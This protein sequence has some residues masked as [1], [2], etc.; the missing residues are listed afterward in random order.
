MLHRISRDAVAD[1]AEELFAAG[2]RLALVA[3]HDDGDRLRVVYL[4]LAGRPDRRVE[5]E[6]IL[7]ATDPAVPSLAYL[8]FPAS[9]FE[10]EMADLTASARSAIRAA[11]VGPARALAS[12][13]ASDARRCRARTGI[14]AG[15][16]LPLRH[17]RGH[18]GVRDPGR[19]RA[20]RA[21]RTGPLPVLRRRRDGARL[22]ARL[23][24]VHR[25][26][27]K[28]FHGRPQPTRS[29]WPSGSAATPPPVMRWRTAWRS[30]TRSA[31]RCPTRCTGCGRCSSSS[32]GSTTTPPISVRSPTTSDSRWPTPT[33]Q[34]I[35]ERLLR[36]NAAVTGH[37]L[38]RGAIGPG[39]VRAARSSA[40]PPSL[41][42]IAADLAEVA[43]LTLANS[44]VHDRFAG[45]SVLAADDARAMGCLGYVARASGV[46]TDAR[47]DHPT[48]RAARHR[49]GSDDGDVLAR[50]TVR[51]DDFAASIELACQLI[52][53]HTGPIEYQVTAP[54]AHAAPQRRRHRR[55]LARHHRAPRRDATP[56]AA[57][58]AP[59][60]STRPGSTGPP[61][62]S[63]WP[64][65]SFPDFPLTNKSF[66]LSYAG[67]DL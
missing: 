14:R 30:R 24:F 2:F 9:R 33:A 66:N 49:V 39:A 65:R 4:F 40:T 12:R 31:S 5:L 8:S 53:S 67:N 51:R 10:R 13:L 57:S 37:R 45:T 38:L 43:E 56:T 34:R 35:R 60:S 48:D 15:R 44:V 58:P 50:Y 26:L 16:A 54:H 52:E 19:T 27:E 59:R 6:C 41:R 55:G 17:G 63:R 32:S 61:C 28:L 25:G 23:W 11:P 47:L 42:S 64:T 46:R 62:P 29:R 20:R 3:A 18:G 21:D 7:P 22:K 36:L 1:K